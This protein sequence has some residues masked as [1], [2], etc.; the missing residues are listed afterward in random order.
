[1]SIYFN[2]TNITP[3]DQFAVGGTSNFPNGILFGSTPQYRLEATTA[4]FGNTIPAIVNPQN[5]FPQN[6]MADAVFVGNFSTISPP[7]YTPLAQYLKTGITYASSTPY[8][9]EFVD[10]NQANFAPGLN[11]F[12]LNSISSL[13]DA[14]AGTINMGQLASTI[15]GYGWADVS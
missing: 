3:G 2:Q 11:V 13:K 14:T 7:T 4:L 6:W 15:K 9:Q 5:N 8:Y 1:M 10:T 12:T